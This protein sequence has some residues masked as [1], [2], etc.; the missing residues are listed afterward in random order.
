MFSLL[1]TLIFSYDLH[2][3]EPETAAKNIL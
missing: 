2:F 1:H 3:L